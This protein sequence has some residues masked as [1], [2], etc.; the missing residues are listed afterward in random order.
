[1]HGDTLYVTAN[2]LN[3]QADYHGGQSLLQEPFVIFTYPVGKSE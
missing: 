2:Q 1:M 3:R